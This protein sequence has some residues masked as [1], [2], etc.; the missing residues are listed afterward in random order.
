[1]GDA[2]IGD[3]SVRSRQPARRVRIFDDLEDPV[4]VAEADHGSFHHDR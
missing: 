1:V 2:V 3:R 4:V